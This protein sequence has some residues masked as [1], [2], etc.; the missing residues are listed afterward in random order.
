MRKVARAAVPGL[1]QRTQY[2]CVAASVAAALQAL[3]KSQCTEDVVNDV[4]GAGPMRGARWEEALAAI[5]YFGCRGLLMVPATLDWVKSHTDKGHPVLIAWNPEGRPWSHAS[6][7][8][9]VDSQNVYVMDPNCPDP[10]QTTRVVPHAEF[11]KGWSEKVSDKMLVR[12]PAVAVTPEV[13]GQGRQVMASAKWRQDKK[14]DLWWLNRTVNGQDVTLVSQGQEYRGMVRFEAAIEKRRQGMGGDI[15]WPKNGKPKKFDSH[16]AAKAA[17]E[18]E[19]AKMLAK[20]AA[21]RP[22]PT[23]LYVLARV[24]PEGV[25]EVDNR[26][27]STTY[28]HMRRLVNFGFVDIDHK[29][30]KLFLTKE[31]IK[32]RDRELENQRSWG[33]KAG[34]RGFPTQLDFGSHEMYNAALKRLKRWRDLVSLYLTPHGDWNVYLDIEPDDS[35]ARDLFRDLA[36]AGLSWTGHGQKYVKASGRRV[37]SAKKVAKQH[38]KMARWGGLEREAIKWL[39]KLPAPFNTPKQRLKVAKAFLGAWDYFD[40]SD[41]LYNAI[42]KVAESSPFETWEEE[43]IVKS[44]GSG[45]SSNEHYEDLVAGGAATKVA[46]VRLPIKQV[47]W[48]ITKDRKEEQI[49]TAWFLKNPPTDAMLDMVHDL[50]DDWL[51]DALEH[52]EVDEYHPSGGWYIERWSDQPKISWSFEDLQMGI[53]GA[54]WHLEVHTL[55]FEVDWE[56]VQFGYDPY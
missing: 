28:P 3:G 17:L 56:G 41:A 18:R 6:C 35:T 51:S 15:L 7:V 25:N 45:P 47:V 27:D 42:L 22:T 33:R 36:R 11:Y 24:F 34:V 31:G 26:L 40:E 12:R 5:Q 13:D 53:K 48:A 14:L 30:K 49:L 23:N 46:V 29:R 52:V 1:R 50:V 9:D 39:K 43:E 32:A 10:H 20:K 4:L 21:S 2:T 55:A 19:I 38:I 8:F 37:A 54:A 16:E 44:W